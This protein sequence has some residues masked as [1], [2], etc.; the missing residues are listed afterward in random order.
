VKEESSS[1]ERTSIQEKTFDGAVG[2]LS[3]SLSLLLSYRERERERESESE[4]EGTG[5]KKAPYL[6]LGF[7]VR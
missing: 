3:F 7:F 2:T 1:L 4:R 5:G 6:F